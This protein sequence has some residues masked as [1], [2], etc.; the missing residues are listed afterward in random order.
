M[1]STLPE[2]HLKPV[3]LQSIIELVK[4]HD[5]GIAAKLE[6]SYHSASFNITTSS[7]SVCFI[8]NELT[9][10]EA[11]KIQE[12]LVHAES[13]TSM[14]DKVRHFGYLCDAWRP[15]SGKHL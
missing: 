13:T 10:D 9:H 3:D 1:A 12:W 14:A 5:H 8:N 11:G 4:Q 2:I 15:V 7:A 6:D